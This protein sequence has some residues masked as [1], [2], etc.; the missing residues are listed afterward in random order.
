MMT[1]PTS[2]TRR[3][4]VKPLIIAAIT[5]TAVGLVIAGL[6]LVATRGSTGPKK[7]TPF[8]AGLER[9]I[10]HD[11]TAGGPVLYADPY[12]GYRSILFALEQDR[13]VAL[14]SHTW[15]HPSC[16]V[17]WRDSLQRFVDCDGNRLTSEQLPRYPYTVP[18]TGGTKGAA[19]VDV[20][21]LLPPPAPS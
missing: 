16:T 4:D 2:S 9:T 10:R 17:R 14:A 3:S 12:G 6:F 13:L 7:Y 1:P 5:L 19:L 21:S 11:V 18:A 8:P 15:N 20:R